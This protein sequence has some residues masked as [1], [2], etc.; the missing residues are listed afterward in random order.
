MA[1]TDDDLKRLK[2][3][4]ANDETED[5]YKGKKNI[6]CHDEMV[7]LIARLEAAETCIDYLLNYDGNEKSPDY[8]TWHKAG[9]K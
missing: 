5:I 3:D 4:I 7:A 2:A 8:L 6:L 1:F 9:G